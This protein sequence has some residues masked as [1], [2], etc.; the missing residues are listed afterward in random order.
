MKEIQ[1]SND[2]KL[3]ADD[4]H[5]L[6]AMD[7]YTEDECDILFGEKRR[8]SYSKY[9]RLM[10]KLLANDDYQYVEML[11]K[12]YSDLV[13]EHARKTLKNRDISAEIKP[14][15][16]EEK[17]KDDAAWRERAIHNPNLYYMFCEKFG[18]EPVIPKDQNPTL[19]ERE[20]KTTLPFSHDEEAPASSEIHYEY[21]INNKEYDEPLR[22]RAYYVTEGADESFILKQ[23]AG[24]TVVLYGEEAR[25]HI[26]IMK[27]KKATVDQIIEKLSSLQAFLNVEKFRKQMKET[28]MLA[29][30]LFI[31]SER[32]Q[33]QKDFETMINMI[34][35][36][37]LA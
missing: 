6:A 8:I 32:Q 11:A 15:T 5:A 30:S 9:S 10:D 19:L 16:P 29:D 4:I 18:W 24:C 14:M 37:M 25:P 22:F 34:S 3:T 1:N 35:M 36:N 23:L 21:I 20:G 27:D 12:K 33:V 31:S 13:T 28:D 2:G 17:E 26:L 7:R